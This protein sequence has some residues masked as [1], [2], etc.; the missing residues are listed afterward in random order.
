MRRSLRELL[1][2]FRPAR[3]HC[4]APVRLRPSD[5]Y[6]VTSAGASDD[7][8]CAVCILH[9]LNHGALCRWPPAGGSLNTTA[10]R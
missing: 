4:L 9:P 5:Y 7:S 10:A 2:G 6:R 8:C 3:L 1:R